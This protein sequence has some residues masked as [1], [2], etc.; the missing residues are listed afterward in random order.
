M[1]W[2]V[3]GL[4]Q[5]TQS[6]ATVKPVDLVSTCCRLTDASDARQSVC[7]SAMLVLFKKII[8]RETTAPFITH[9]P[10]NLQNGYPEEIR[11]T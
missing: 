4:E 6:M 8:Q 2:A 9:R 7:C 1:L 11:A 5:D 3:I 10:E